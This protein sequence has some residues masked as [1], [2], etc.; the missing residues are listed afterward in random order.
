MYIWPLLLLTALSIGRHLEVSRL[1]P[2]PCPPD[3]WREG[4]GEEV[5]PFF[6]L[7]AYEDSFHQPGTVYLIGKV[8]VEQANT[9]VR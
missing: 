9:Y 8:W 7:D 5:L 6:W 1:T 2:P 4:E 3:S